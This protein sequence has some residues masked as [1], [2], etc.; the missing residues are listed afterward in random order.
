MRSRVT[1]KFCPTSSRVLVALADAEPPLD[2]ALFARRQRLEERFRLLAQIHVD[3]GFDRRDRVLVLDE[4]TEVRIF[5]FADGRLEGDRL[6]RDLP[7]LVEGVVARS[8]RQIRSFTVAAGQSMCR[9]ETRR[10]RGMGRGGDWGQANDF[11]QTV[12][13]S[14]LEK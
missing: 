14:S 11:S 12:R 4:V 5:H 8:L 10:Q 3:H 9:A 13:S 1:A 2:D 6:L 7:D